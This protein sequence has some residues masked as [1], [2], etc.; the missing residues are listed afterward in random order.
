MTGEQI[1]QASERN[2]H[3]SELR[4]EAF[5]MALYVAI[6]L[7]AALL[8]LPENGPARNHVV[9][10]VWGVTLGLALVH[11]FA[12]RMSARL[13]GAGRVHAQDME[14]AGAQLA[15]AAVVAL[16]AT[17]PVILFPPS[18]EL[19][20]VELVLAGFISLVGYAVAT[21]GGATRGRALVYAVCVLAAAV[22]IAELKNLLAGH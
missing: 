5:T 8:A 16:L 18:W 3:V 2:E 22:G 11:W 9:G 12:F 15:G 6:C 21:A 13:V 19:E 4:K 14:A 20:V 17:V 1:A 7:L 10:V